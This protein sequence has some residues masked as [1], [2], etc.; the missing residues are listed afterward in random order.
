MAVFPIFRQFVRGRWLGSTP[1]ASVEIVIVVVSGG[2][3][4]S[5]S[6]CLEI[7]QLR[8]EAHVLLRFPILDC[9][10]ET[11]FSVLDLPIQV[12]FLVVPVSR[13]RLLQPSLKA[14]VFGFSSL[15]T[16]AFATLGVAL[17]AKSFFELIPGFPV[18][19]LAVF[20][21][22]VRT[23]A[24]VVVAVIRGTVVDGVKIVVVAII[25]IRAR[26][27][28]G[29]RARMTRDAVVVAFGVEVDFERSRL[30]VGYAT[31]ILKYNFFVSLLLS[32]HYTE[33]LVFRAH[34]VW[35]RGLWVK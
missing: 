21:V 28:I 31:K 5:D 7:S 23:A 18:A 12:A 16:I 2:V 26:S 15:G 4:G 1:I 3:V 32:W 20:L 34:I 33:V 24:I 6:L 25:V 8:R 35:T 27:L 29:G 11:G 13:L 10:F 22:V 30:V 17:T 14:F 9:L 19:A